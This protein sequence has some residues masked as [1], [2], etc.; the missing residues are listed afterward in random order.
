MTRPTFLYVIEAQN[1]VLKIGSSETPFS[2]A[3]ACHAHSPVPCRL[4]AAWEGKREEEARLHHSF[5]AHCSHSEWFRIE[6]VVAAFADFVRGTGVEA[7]PEWDAISF[8]GRDE[9]RRIAAGRRSAALKAK[10]S[11]PEYRQAQASLRAGYRR[12][13]KAGR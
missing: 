3:A 7:I 9:R 6:G 10:W 5:A 13:G 11:D 8:A 2:R 4:I 12:R 1:G